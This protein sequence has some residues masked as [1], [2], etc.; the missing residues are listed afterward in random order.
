M[1]DSGHPDTADG[2]WVSGPLRRWRRSTPRERT[3]GLVV[4]L[5]A[6][7]FG[8]AVFWLLGGV[9]HDGSGLSGAVFFGVWMF[10]IYLYEPELTHLVRRMNR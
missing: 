8:A 3:V 6:C 9:M 10:L 4:Q 2:R 7:A 1:D 5:T